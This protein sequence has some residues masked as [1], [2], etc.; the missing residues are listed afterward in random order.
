MRT[1]VVGCLLAVAVSIA[2]CSDRPATQVMIGIATDLDAPNPLQRLQMKIERFEDEQQM[3]VDVEPLVTK[4]WQID[5]PPLGFELPGSLVTFTGDESTPLIRATVTAFDPAGGGM[6]RRQSIFRLIKEKTLYTRMGIT[7]RCLDNA[8]CPNAKT[9][10]EGRCRDPELKALPEYRPERR[11]ELN[12]ECNSGTT[13]INTTTGNPLMPIGTVCPANQVCLEGAC[14]PENVFGSPLP[15]PQMLTV[16]LLVSDAGGMPISGAT[17]RAEDGP[18]SV[19]RTLRTMAPATPVSPAPATMATVSMTAPG[20]YQVSTSTD[21]LTSELE[22]T[23]NAPG[24]VPQVVTIPV[25]PGVVSYQVPAVLF[26]LTE[27]VLMPGE[28]RPLM[29]TGGGRTATLQVPVPANATAPVRVRYALMDGRYLPGQAIRSGAGGDLLQAAA[30]LYLENVG[31]PKFPEQTRVTLGA[32]T[33]PAVFGAEGRAAAYRLDMQGQWDPRESS[34]FQDAQAPQ[35]TPSSGG[36]WAIA[37]VTP[38]PACV[39]GKIRKPDGTACAGTRVRLLGPEGVSAVDSTGA[40]G[41]F[42]G[43]AAQQE[44][45]ILAVGGTTRTIYVPATSLTGAHCGVTE[46]GACADIGEVVVDRAEDC[47]RPPALVAGRK[48][49]GEACTSTLECGGLA[50]C[51]QGFCVGEGY[52]RVTMTWAVGSDFDLYVKL[53]NGQTLGEMVKAVK[54]VGEIDV[55]QCTGGCAAAKHLENA[56]LAGAPGSYEVWVQNFGGTA[57]GP[58]TIEVFAD[59]KRKLMDQTVNVPAGVDARSPSLTFTL[60]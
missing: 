38:R 2:G 48:L 51:Q 18:V 20:L 30:V 14:Y 10:I 35:L 45:A 29:L 49:R 17:I 31:W 9:C 12:V 41:A 44:A 26:P 53:P 19:V 4:D 32:A 42:C 3:W 46:A 22:L 23:V 52:A 11:P 1:P 5:D 43:G 55:E 54:G 28:N 47:D 7:S 33:T 15:A 60:P 57:P 50:S 59:G 37:N 27:T 24:F 25:K 56:V 39:R 58:A 16:S 40:D 8:D 13:F 34:T 6:V 21:V 36:F